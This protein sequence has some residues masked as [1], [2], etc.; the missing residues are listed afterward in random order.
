MSYYH[1]LG[2]E[3]EDYARK[4]DNEF[5]NRQLLEI[6]RDPIARRAYSAILANRF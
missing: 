5:I 6:I 2:R 4:A 3:A 1:W